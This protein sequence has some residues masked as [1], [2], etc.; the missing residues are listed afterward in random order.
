MRVTGSWMVVTSGFSCA[1]QLRQLDGINTVHT[2]QLLHR[3]F[4][5]ERR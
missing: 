3:A 5:G 2:H 1:E 4:V